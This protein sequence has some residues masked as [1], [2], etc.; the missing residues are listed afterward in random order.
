MTAPTTTS[1]DFRAES[2][3]VVPGP[4]HGRSRSDPTGIK[5]ARN[6]VPALL[7]PEPPQGTWRF[8]PSRLRTGTRWWGDDTPPTFTG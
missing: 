5:A 6:R 8:V 7:G 3:Q 2:A 1:R 4:A